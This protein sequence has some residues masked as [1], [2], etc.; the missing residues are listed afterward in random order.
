M[1]LSKVFT[2]YLLTVVL[3]LWL[4]LYKINVQKATTP[5][6]FFSNIGTGQDNSKGMIL[7]Y[8]SIPKTGSTGVWRVIYTLESKNSFN[9]EYVN[10]SSKNRVFSFINKFKFKF[11]KNVSL[12][13]S[14]RPTLFHENFHFVNFCSMGFR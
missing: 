9:V 4:L 1:E 13:Y 10:V 12:W 3:I 14:P 6:P 2:I 5:L 8:N 7:I 11:A